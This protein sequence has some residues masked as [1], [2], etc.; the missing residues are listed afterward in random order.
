M[1]LVRAGRFADS[2]RNHRRKKEKTLCRDVTGT[3]TNGVTEGVLSQLHPGS[4]PGAARST[5]ERVGRE[6]VG[7][8]RG[9]AVDE[10]SRSGSGLFGALPEGQEDSACFLET[11]PRCEGRLLAGAESSFDGGAGVGVVGRER[12]KGSARREPGR[13][14]AV[15]VVLSCAGADDGGDVDAGPLV[16]EV[17][18]EAAVA[19]GPTAEFGPGI[20]AGVGVEE[21]SRVVVG[22]DGDAAGSPTLEQSV[23]NSTRTGAVGPG[24]EGAGDAGH[25]DPGAGVAESDP[26]GG[27][28]CRL[29]CGVPSLRTSPAQDLIDE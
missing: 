16:A 29:S 23:G 10:A 1:R 22:G 11:A 21:G 12:G 26:G 17:G 19:V 7:V 4:D 14:D 8:V 6:T 2:A 18:P 27:G 3:V 25:V 24:L 9:E 20:A 5:R 28:G 15:V 13:E